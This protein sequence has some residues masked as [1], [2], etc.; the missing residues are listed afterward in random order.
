M[1]GDHDECRWSTERRSTH[2]HL[3]RHTS[4]RIEVASRIDGVSVCLL[5][6]HVQ[7]RPQHHPGLRQLCSPR[8]IH[9]VSDP[10]VCY[11]R[12]AVLE[13]NVLGLDVTMNHP[14]VMR[15]TQRIGNF[16]HDP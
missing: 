15:V 8:L 16:A 9:G 7:R 3:V 13:K 11:D 1:P 5:R 14:V 10:E 4:E 2:Q 6:A 12:S